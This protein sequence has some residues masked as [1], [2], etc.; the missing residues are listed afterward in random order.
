VVQGVSPTQ[1]WMDVKRLSARGFTLYDVSRFLL[2][3]TVADNSS[4]HAE[5]GSQP[6]F[7]AAFPSAL[8]PVLPCLGS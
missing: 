4:K 7:Q 2:D 5:G 1:I 8:F 6:V 3:Y